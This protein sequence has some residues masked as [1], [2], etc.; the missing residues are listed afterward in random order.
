MN[1]E[2]AG[3]ITR[4]LKMLCPGGIVLFNTLRPGAMYTFG[5][6]AVRLLLTEY[7]YFSFLG[8]ISPKV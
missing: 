6:T 8:M 7:G 4:V 5:L 3:T 1:P 2:H